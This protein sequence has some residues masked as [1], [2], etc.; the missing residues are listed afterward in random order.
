MRTCRASGATCLPYRAA[1]GNPS[2]PAKGIRQKKPLGIEVPSIDSGRKSESTRTEHTQFEFPHETN[3]QLRRWGL[4]TSAMTGKSPRSG[5][6]W[7]PPLYALTQNGKAK[8]VQVFDCLQLIHSVGMQLGYEFIYGSQ[9]SCNSFWLCCRVQLH[10]LI[11]LFSDPKR[12]CRTITF[13]YRPCF[14]KHFLGCEI[15]HDNRLL[16][17]ATLRTLAR[18]AKSKAGT[19]TSLTD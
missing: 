10:Q 11:E 8:S 17:P 2:T 6:A 3:P 15:Y 18:A 12:Y 7:R 14:L 1:P 5:G 16:I 19:P 13:Q 4:A 9:F